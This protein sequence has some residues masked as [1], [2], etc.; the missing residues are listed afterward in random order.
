MQMKIFSDD[1]KN[2]M[3]EEFDKVDKKSIVLSVRINDE[4]TYYLDGGKVFKKDNSYWFSYQSQSPEG[5]II[6]K[7]IAEEF[8]Y[9]VREGAINF[10]ALYLKYPELEGDNKVN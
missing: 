4:N 3:Q 7:E 9:G 2:K 8:Y 10:M 1:D 6:T 5:A